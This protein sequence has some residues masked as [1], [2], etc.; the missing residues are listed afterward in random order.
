MAVTSDSTLAAVML[1]ALFEAVV[2]PG[3]MAP[4][5]WVAHTEGAMQLILLR[6]TDQCR[7]E[8]SKW[9]FLHVSMT[10]RACCI[11]NDTPVP[12]DFVALA[13]KVRLL[14]D[15]RDPALLMAAP[16]GDKVV[17]FI[18]YTTAPRLTGRSLERRI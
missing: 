5:N 9:L 11:Q 8:V 17:W 14:L 2:F 6:G 10:L 18:S 1:L 4:T 15:P 12:T 16:F 13:E 7:S 3:G